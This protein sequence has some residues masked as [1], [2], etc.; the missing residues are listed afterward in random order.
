MYSKNVTVE[1]C[2]CDEVYF[3]FYSDNSIDIKIDKCN[4]SGQLSTDVYAH[5]LYFGHET[6]NADV[7][8]CILTQNGVDGANIVK[9]GSNEGVS[10]KIRL[11]D[12]TLNG[13]GSS[14][15]YV[16]TIFGLELTNCKI[17]W[18]SK[19]GYGRVIQLINNSTVKF[20]NCE[21]EFDSFDKYTQSYDL[22]NSLIEFSNCV[23]TIKNTIEK[24]SYLPFVSGCKMK[25]DNCTFN[26]N[27]NYSYN[28]MTPDF[29][30]V[31]FFNCI[32]HSKVKLF[33]GYYD[34]NS[35]NYT[36]TTTPILKMYNCI[37][38][39]LSESAMGVNSLFMNIAKDGFTPECH[40]VNFVGYKCSATSGSN[41][42]KLFMTNV[43]TQ[44]LKNN[45]IDLNP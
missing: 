38:E 23:I 10:G 30:H 5:V 11:T 28:L 7:T 34:A 3:P 24:Y 22:T 37:F 4:F 45:A 20:F 14:V 31:E 12:C 36:K 32:F 41:S 42:G 40:I 25:F 35:V 13:I 6:R 29:L 1:N 15:F 2:S 17:S 26:I 27:I 21:C 43:E 9:C 8:N 39:N 16:D 18:K 19:S 44:Y 33:I